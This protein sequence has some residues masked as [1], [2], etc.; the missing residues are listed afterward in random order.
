MPFAISARPYFLAYNA[1]TG[2]VHVDRVLE[3]GHG[4]DILLKGTWGAGWTH[5]MP[6]SLNGH[7]YFLA[8]NAATGEATFNAINE[9]FLLAYNTEER[10]VTADHDLQAAD[11]TASQIWVKFTKN[12]FWHFHAFL[13]DSGTMVGD[14]YAIGFIVDGDGHGATMTGTL[15]AKYSGPAVD[16]DRYISGYDPWIANNWPTILSAG[17][18]FKLHTAPDVGSALESLI[19]TL[20]A[21]G[22]QLIK[23]IGS[24]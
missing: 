3:D 9:S 17:F 11:V 13:H 12:G 18:R 22:P 4:F 20:I 2:E 23:L 21:N 7:P 8:Y 24:L 6:Y 5:F 10:L 15:G 19:D 16:N 14:S 1:A